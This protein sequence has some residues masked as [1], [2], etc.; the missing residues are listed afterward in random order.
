MDDL[1]PNAEPGSI[2]DRPIRFYNLSDL[3][4][5]YSGKV[6]AHGWWSLKV[7]RG[8]CRT[9][10]WI[11]LICICVVLLIT[12]CSSTL[13]E[14]LMFPVTTS[15]VIRK[16][17]NL[18][19]PAI[20]ICNM[21]AILSD[22]QAEGREAG[23][24]A[25]KKELAEKLGKENDYIKSINLQRYLGSKD[26]KTR[27]TLGHKLKN[28][29][30]YCSYFGTTCSSNDFMLVLSTS[31]GNCYTFNAFGNRTAATFGVTESLL[32]VLDTQVNE[33]N[34]MY[35][36]STG[37]RI[38]IHNNSAFPFPEADGFNISPG[39]LTY[40]GVH[41]KLVKHIKYPYSDC[42]ILTNDEMKD[43][44]AYVGILPHVI[45]SEMSCIKTCNQI[46]LF[47]HCYCFD[48]ALPRYRNESPAFDQL[49]EEL[50][51]DRFD[52]PK[53]TI[54]CQPE[55][56]LKIKQCM[57]WFQELFISRKTEEKAKVDDRLC[58]KCIPVCSQVKYETRLSFGA[59][60]NL[61]HFRNT[62]NEKLKQFYDTRK[63]NKERLNYLIKNLAAVNIY[64]EDLEQT[65]NEDAVKITTFNF[66]AD[67]GGHMGLWMGA[68]I[69]TVFEF[70]E[71][72][73]E[74]VYNY[75]FCQQI[76]G[77]RK[78][79][80]DESTRRKI[81]RRNTM[82]KILHEEEDKE[83]DLLF[84][85]HVLNKANLPNTYEKLYHKRFFEVETS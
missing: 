33:Y 84:L 35:Q 79:E 16:E 32:L 20:T 60:R 74:I 36:T 11:V 75:L 85:Q 77:K 45:Y 65:I 34:K 53:K 49:K 42:E 4:T 27:R 31:Y 12:L 41:R 80:Y 78:S 50:G 46:E 67:L 23:Y 30:V 61:E 10:Y 56:D 57:D 25:I 3:L 14:F 7:A 66:I 1:T 64:Y 8:K 81:L 48:P 73:F 9:W 22:E 58:P 26:Q 29:L 19:F 44:D 54:Y 15:V 59:Y 18:S 38:A 17:V 40:V 43:R 6:S 76:L 69:I 47:R 13:L 21:N 62:K 5:Y 52:N 39:L 68:S 55:R 37:F 63:N 72:L 51:K 24:S 28:M 82:R 71:F 2:L 70:I 83:L